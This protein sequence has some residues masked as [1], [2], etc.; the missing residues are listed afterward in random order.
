MK[1]MCPAFSQPLFFPHCM[2]MGRIMF[3]SLAKCYLD[4][5]LAAKSKWLRSVALFPG[6]LVSTDSVIL[7]AAKQATGKTEL[8]KV[9]F[10]VGLRP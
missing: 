4:R 10:L 3:G 1:E 8:F 9:F 6:D 2:L 5:V 7:L